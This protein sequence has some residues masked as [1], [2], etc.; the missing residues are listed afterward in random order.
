MAL[1]GFKKVNFPITEMGF[2][3]SL[4]NIEISSGNSV[5]VIVDAQNE[6]G[7]WGEEPRKDKATLAVL[8]ALACAGEYLPPGLQP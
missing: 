5:I 6:D 7:S 3:K 2:M 8:S 1:F 4:Q